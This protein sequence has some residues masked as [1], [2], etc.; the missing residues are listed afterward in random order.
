MAFSINHNT[1]TLVTTF[2]GHDIQYKFVCFVHALRT[3]T[4]KVT[5]TTVHIIVDDTF[6][7][8]HALAFHG[9]DS[10]KYGGRY[11]AGKLQGTARLGT[12]ANHTGN[13]G[14]QVLLQEH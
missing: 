12:V 11:T 14:N 6:Y 3:D 9:E 1:H 8:G 7:R 4:G 10:R 5:D 13:V 2:V